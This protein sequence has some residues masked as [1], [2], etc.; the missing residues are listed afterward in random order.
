MTTRSE[1]TD[2]LHAQGWTEDRFGNLKRNSANVRIKFQAT[3]LRV[4]KKIVYKPIEF[5]NQTSYTPPPEWKNVVSDYYKN[6]AIV[7]GHVVIGS[8]RLK[9]Q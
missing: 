9:P 2:I 1:I 3:S 4:E 5:A 6:I 8:Y 7:D